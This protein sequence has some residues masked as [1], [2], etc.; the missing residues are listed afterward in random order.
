MFISKAAVPRGAGRPG[1][2]GG[3]RVTRTAGVG[4]C[5]LPPPLRGLRGLAT[6][7]VRVLLP[8]TVM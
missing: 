2:R 1:W 3:T 5:D 7:A 4:Y 6:F 8:S